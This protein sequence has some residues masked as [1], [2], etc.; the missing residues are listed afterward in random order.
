MER[1]NYFFGLTRM[2]WIPL[3]T[4]LIFIGFGVWCL[5]D[6]APS[7]E[8]LAYIFAGAIIAIGLFNLCYGVSCYNSNHGWAL[9][10]GAG[11]VELIFG[12]FM[13]YVPAPV[14]TVFFVYGVGL[15]VI[16]SAIYSFFGSLMYK[17][18]SPLL[19]CL[20]VLFLLGAIATGIMII[21][22]SS[23]VVGAAVIGWIYIGISLICFGIFRLLLS[24]KIY[25]ANKAFL[26]GKY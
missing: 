16:F 5:C 26:N 10:M 14:L 18:N 19:T 13:F 7:L 15:Y 25:Q 22:G 17:G 23:V 1:T 3:L 11:A 21:L 12:I 8:I 4:G 9:A 20:I 2:W 6:P 24:A